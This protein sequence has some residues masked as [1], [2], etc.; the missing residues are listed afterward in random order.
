MKVF[1]GSSRR[2]WVALVVVLLTQ[3]FLVLWTSRAGWVGWMPAGAA[4]IERTSLFGASLL[5]AAVAWAGVSLRAH[6]VEAW[7]LVGR[8]DLHALYGGPFWW[9]VSA[10]VVATGML[11]TAVAVLTRQST[12]SEFLARYALS[13]LAI[14]STS[15]CASGIGIL[16][17][18]FVP[19]FV[20]IPAAFVVPYAVSVGLGGY[21]AD[22]PISAVAVP[23]FLALEY[24]WP[25]IETP[26]LRAVSLTCIALAI[27]LTLDR[28]A[29][30]ARA[31]M[32]LA[33]A[34]TAGLLLAAG[35]VQPIPGASRVDCQ[36][37]SPVVCFDGT[38]DAVR[39]DYQAQ[40]RDGLR[41]LPRE[42]WPAVVSATDQQGPAEAVP[43]PPVSG[44]YQPARVISPATVTAML[45]DVMF[46]TE[47]R[48]PDRVE[49]SVAMTAWWRTHLTLP[50]DG[51]VYAGQ[52]PFS[53]PELGPARAAGMRL[54][55]ID[56]DARDRIIV[57]SM[58]R[59]R[60]CS[61]PAQA[62]P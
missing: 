31:A 33:S 4:A 9:G 45:G 16:L 18:R 20:A 37:G 12:T 1:R 44:K 49:L 56:A 58:R 54:E 7:A 10:S 36:Q 46:R 38:Q 61:L 55:T 42:V 39:A 50:L 27:V 14:L 43:I 53:S 34:A 48:S 41:L 47:C 60:N 17:A 26:L 2:V 6:D 40:L 25:G 51:G 11:S 57:A 24:D 62:L 30:A 15:A 3:G 13:V 32:W 29:R 21:L 22:S 8:R 52:N 19:H 28:R 23:N 5:A 59:L 35:A